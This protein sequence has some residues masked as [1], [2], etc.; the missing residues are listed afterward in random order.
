PG[1]GSIME[2]PPRTIQPAHVV[3]TQNLAVITLNRPI[4]HREYP[5][6]GIRDHNRFARQSVDQQLQQALFTDRLTAVHRTPLRAQSQPRIEIMRGQQ[7]Q[8]RP[9]RYSVLIA[10]GRIGLHQFLAVRHA[11][12]SA[13]K[14]KCGA[15]VWRQL[16]LLDY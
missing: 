13:V 7:A 6:I 2:S 4:G 8:Y 5:K 14:E 15:P 9:V 16:G 10:G 1:T 12:R 3:K 11:Y